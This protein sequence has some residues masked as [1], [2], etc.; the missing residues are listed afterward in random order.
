MSN[1]RMV[2]EGMGV[3]HNGMTAILPST[4]EI[5]TVLA[6]KKKYYTDKEGKLYVPGGIP[7]ELGP[8]VESWT[9]TVPTDANAQ[10]A[11]FV[12]DLKDMG[13]VIN[14]AS[15]EVTGQKEYVKV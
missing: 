4:D 13:H 3:H 15:F 12:K 14:H 2:I 6:E 8:K 1:W 5:K 11:D 10:F 9:P 7:A